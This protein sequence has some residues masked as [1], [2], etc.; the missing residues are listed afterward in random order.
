MSDQQPA[1]VYPPAPQPVPATFV[2]Q[3]VPSAAPAAPVLPQLADQQATAVQIPEGGYAQRIVRIPLPQ[4]HLAEVP[5]PW[6]EMRNPGLMAQE[7]LEEIGHGLT[8]VTIGPDGQPSEADSELVLATMARLLRR[9]CMWDASS[10]DDVPPL[11][12]ETVTV[13]SLRKAPLG[14]FRAIGAAFVELQN[15]Q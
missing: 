14:V 2:P 13:E 10:E 15:P 6:V 3:P 11:L 8:G 4:F 12:P 7:A 9:W 1:P 5:A